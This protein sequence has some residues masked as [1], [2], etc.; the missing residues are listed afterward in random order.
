MRTALFLLWG[1]FLLLVGG[2][3][4][5]A[6]QIHGRKT[7]DELEKQKSSLDDQLKAIQTQKTALDG[8]VKKLQDKNLAY[9]KYLMDY[10][11]SLQKQIDS[12]NADILTNQPLCDQPLDVTNPTPACVPYFKSVAQ[13]KDLSAKMDI[14]NKLLS[15]TSSMMSFIR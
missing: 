1:F 9:Q 4:S 8:S 12:V 13:Q 6:I 11:A 5:L 7:I 10:K 14:V 2:L 15:E 3:S